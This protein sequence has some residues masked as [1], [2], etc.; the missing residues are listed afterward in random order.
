LRRQRRKRSRG[1]KERILQAK[2]R[3]SAKKSDRRRNFD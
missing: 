3:Q 1:A 2:A